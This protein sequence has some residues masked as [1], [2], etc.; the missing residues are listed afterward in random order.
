MDFQ[1]IVLIIISGLGVFHGIFIAFLL[2][3]HKKFSNYPGRILGVL[4]I[5]LSLRIGKSVVLE[6]YN[7]LEFIY[8]YIGLC[9]MMFMGPL[10]YLYCRAIIKQES[11]FQIKDLLH[12]IPGGLFVLFGIGIGNQSESSIPFMGAVIV[13]FVIYA[14]LLLYLLKSKIQLINNL[15]NIP[16]F[17]KTKEWLNILFY[18]LLLIWGVYVLNLFEDNIP[19]IIGPILYSVIVYLITYLVISNKYLQ[20]LSGIKYKTSVIEDEE[21][22]NLFSQIEIVIKEEKLFLNPNI[23]LGML[24]KI[25]GVSPQKISLAIN[26]KLGYNFNEYINR[27]RISQSIEII[28]DPK[29]NLLTIASISVDSGFNSLSSFNTCF[30]KY[31]GKTPSA[32][33]NIH[34]P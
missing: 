20:F 12:F 19:Y 13:F 17:L 9:L 24:S 7:N 10:F 11:R 2:W 30:K 26:S 33:R 16:N 1:Q 8:I 22:D 32:Y 29:S 15:Q 21:V 5:L 28:K 18:G 3:T 6:F 14:H 31:V 27:Q 34:N 25:I 4:M 23:S